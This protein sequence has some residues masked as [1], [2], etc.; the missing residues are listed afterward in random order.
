MTAEPSPALLAAAP[1]SAGDEEVIRLDGVS[2]CYRVPYEPV[3]SLKEYVISRLKGK[4]GH[5]LLRALDGVSLSVRAGEVFGIV[6]HN[7]AGKT[8]LL[9]TVARVLRPT[10]GRVWVKGEVVPLLQLG[11]GCHPELTGRENI[12]LNATLLGHTRRDTLDRLDGIVD[13]AGIGDFIDAPLRTYSTGMAARVGFAV[14][15]AWKPDILI[16]DEALAVGD[17]A[18]QHKCM[19]RLAAFRKA[20]ATVLMVSH[21]SETVMEMC[22]RAAWL[23]HGVLQVVGPAKEVIARY[24]EGKRLKT[25]SE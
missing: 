20:G 16:L 23:D 4:G 14:A 17:E 25:G 6:G 9:K 5:R 15:T 24:R 13:F 3:A 18:F 22:A 11:S 10:D 19:D 21:G 12:F 7:G 1:T 2:V 8:T